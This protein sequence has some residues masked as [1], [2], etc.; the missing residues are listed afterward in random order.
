MN[1]FLADDVADLIGARY[2]KYIDEI[3]EL[4]VEITHMTEQEFFSNYGRNGKIHVRTRAVTLEM[5]FKA[6][7]GAV[8]FI[9]IQVI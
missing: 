3:I 7:P 2:Y 8:K 6:T 5:E 9:G 1:Y 4:F